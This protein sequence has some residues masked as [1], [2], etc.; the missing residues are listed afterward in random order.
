MFSKGRVISLQAVQTDDLIPDNRLLSDETDLLEHQAIAKAVAEIA[1]T[2]RTPVNIALF[3]AWG[4]GKSSIYSMVESH[5]TAIASNVKVAR[6]DAWKYGGKE[7][8]RNF[9][10]SLARD[11]AL[12]DEPELSTGLERTVSDTRIALGSW[13]WRNKLSLVGGLLAAI[14]VAVL[15]VVLIATA[16]TVFAQSGFAATA[17][18]LIPNVGTVFGLALLAALLG[19]KVLEGLTVTTETPAPEDADQFAKRFSV[20]VTKARSKSRHPLIVFI[21]ELDRCAP[22]DVVATLRDLKTFLDQ[23]NCAFIVAA[24]R[25]VIVRSLREEATEAKPIREEEPYYATPGAFLDKIFQHQISLPPLRAR[26]LTDFA[27]ALTDAQQGGVWA[28]MRGVGGGCYDRAIFALVPVHVRSP[29]RVK[30]LLN[31]FATNARI[32]EARGLPWLDRTHEIA[33]LTVLQTEFPSLIDDLRRVPRLLTYLRQE[34]DPA[35]A[36]VREIV[37]KYTTPRDAEST[38]GPAGDE[39]INNDE[40]A[41]GVLLQQKAN[42]TLRRQLHNYLNKIAAAKIQDPRPDLLYLKP[43]VNRDRLPDPALGDAIDFATDTAPVQTIAAFADEDSETLAIAVPLLA[44]EGDNAVGVGKEFAYE[45]ACLLVERV[46]PTDLELLAE[47]VHPSLRAALTSGVLTN[48]S[49]PGALLVAAWSGDFEVVRSAFGSSRVSDVPDELLARFTPL[50]RRVPDTVASDIASLLAARFD[51]APEPLLKA[52]ASVPVSTAQMLWSEVSESVVAA[53]NELELPTPEESEE[54][55]LAGAGGTGSSSES[56]GPTGQG[57]ALAAALVEAAQERDDGEALVSD[58]FASLQIPPADKL[59]IQWTLSNADRVVSPMGSPVRKARHAILGI[60]AF[61]SGAWMRWGAYLPA[62]DDVVPGEQLRNEATGL[63]LRRLL[64]QFK[65]SASAIPIGELADLTQRVGEWSSHSVTQIAKV[66]G[67]TL[68]AMPWSEAG[69]DSDAREVLW[70]RKRL[71]YRTLLAL[72]PE[73]NPTAG[74]GAILIDDLSSVVDA[75]ELD[76]QTVTRFA[77]VCGEFPTNLIREI[78]DRIDAFN[79]LAGQ[80]ALTLELRLL[81]RGHYGG[82]PVPASDLLAL[83]EALRSTPISGAWLSLRPSVKDVMAVVG[84]FPFTPAALAAY[85]SLQSLDDRTELWVAAEKN[86]LADQMLKALGKYGVG[87]EAVDHIRE[88][89][90]GIS[91]EPERSKKVKRLRLAQPAEGSAASA[92]QKSAGILATDL[93]RNN[94]AGDLRSAA[95]LMS[96]AGGAVARDRVSLRGLFDEQAKAHRNAFTKSLFA[97]LEKLGLLSKKKSLKELVF[98]SKEKS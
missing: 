46:D 64:P 5:L 77:E 83:E 24:D 72:A 7:L 9:V 4:S 32:V 52:L 16:A 48:E 80:E 14:V 10:D 97:D 60:R 29:R 63:V 27:R 65:E 18:S 13:L 74:V 12:A 11:L 89:V 59:I 1:L 90:N 61:M 79:E 84:E 81:V 68:D 17:K 85:A 71:F 8:K 45:S 56:A 38:D 82:Q 21:D 25:E 73:A 62:L 3:G 26:A 78:S 70:G 47:Q 20:L 41:S 6:Y 31:N 34:E 88:C 54:V 43:A 75:Y 96:W 23:E 57:I 95:E 94:V 55:K 93:M 58:I 42:E 67:E 76:R 2:A 87:A 51:T 44:I 22:S 39:I 92:V 86:R 35:S 66:A 91:R 33:V 49:L 36:E 19:P 69:A 28:D 53:I 98:G 40:S 37:A 30:V 50:L 15:W